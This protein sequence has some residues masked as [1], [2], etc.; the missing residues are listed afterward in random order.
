MDLQKS[1]QFQELNV[2]LVSIAVDPVT[3][4]AEDASRLGITTPFVSDG[5]GHVSEAY[6]SASWSLRG[7]EPGH[8]FV[9][10]DEQGVVRW[11]KDYAASENGAL[12]YVAVDELYGEVASRQEL[13]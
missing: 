2:Q 6:G 4:L 1:D 3:N 7:G 11:V 10:V 12:M 8:V 9:F 13:P 5:D